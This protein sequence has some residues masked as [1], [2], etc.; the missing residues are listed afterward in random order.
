M[1]ISAWIRLSVA[2]FATALLVGCAQVP[3][4]FREPLP[5]PQCNVAEPSAPYVG[6]GNPYEPGELVTT[7]ARIAPCEEEAPVAMRVHAPHGP[8]PYPVV[9]FQHGFQSYNYT[10][11]EIL[12]HLA[13][14]GFVVVAPQMYAPGLRALAGDPTADEEAEVSADLIEWIRCSLAGAAHVSADPSRIGIAGHSRGGKV[15]WRV[16][17]NDPTLASAVAGIDPV[18]GTG[19]PLGNEPR[20]VDGPF[21]FPF[22]SL[23]LGTGQAGAC[24]PEG[25][26][27]VQFYGASASP[28]YH[29]VAPEAGHGDM[30]DEPW[31]QASG[32]LCPAGPDLEGGRRLTAGLMVAFYRG[33]LQGDASAFDWLT[34]VDAAPV[35]IEV[36]S[37]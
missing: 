7:I 13:S 25:D 2:V 15:A 33:A 27:H 34:D 10:Y 28:A 9:V 14:H 31:S 26:N 3:N 1:S 12:S 32:L 17:K 29:V 23:V 37:R 24:A 35:P 16:L 21:E 36:E 4:V 8:G 11:D 30:L 6:S 5:E 20:V 18:D 22:P 19:G